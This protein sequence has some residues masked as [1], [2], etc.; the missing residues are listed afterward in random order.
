MYYL[1]R[2]VG[3]FPS[4]AHGAAS[5][6]S[7][8]TEGAVTR[9]LAD[10]IAQRSGAPAGE[11]LRQAWQHV[12]VFLFNGYTL[13]TVIHC[14]HGCPGLAEAGALH[15]SAEADARVTELLSAGCCVLVVRDAYSRAAWVAASDFGLGIAAAA[16]AAE[17]AL[18]DAG[19]AAETVP[20][21]AAAAAAPAAAAGGEAGGDGADPLLQLLRDNEAQLCAWR[22]ADLADDTQPLLACEVE[23]EARLAPEGDAVPSLVAASRR[24]LAQQCVLEA[25]QAPRLRQLACAQAA[26]ARPPP[27]PSQEVEPWRWAGRQL[28][29]QVRARGSCVRGSCVRLIRRFAPLARGS[30]GCSRW[31]TRP[32]CCRCRCPT[33]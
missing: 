20:A 18:P 14:P 30:R 5:L 24:A 23:A 6:S 15:G 32:R 21:A 25:E 13:L 12:R 19:P 11:A 33:R 10:R 31:P 22:A 29:A 7:T 17:A 27:S 28:L 1:L 8:I 3:R 26:S 16:D 4:P 9:L 2:H